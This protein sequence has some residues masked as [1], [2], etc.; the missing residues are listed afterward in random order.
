MCQLAQDTLHE[1]SS[2]TCKVGCPAVTEAEASGRFVPIRPQCSCLQ[3]HT[4]RNYTPA[5]DREGL[6]SGKRLHHDARH[7]LA[8]Q[9]RRCLKINC[10]PKLRDRRRA[11]ERCCTGAISRLILRSDR[12]KAP[13]KGVGACGLLIWLKTA[14]VLVAAV[15][16]C[17]QAYVF[18]SNEGSQ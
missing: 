12:L 17:G 4:S 2:I 15:A 10:A 6:I 9:L 5:S 1:P 8:T 14:L 18:F 3:T 16:R 11:G 7:P 13:A